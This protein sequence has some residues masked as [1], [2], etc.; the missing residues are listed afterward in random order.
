MV[1]PGLC[2]C[3]RVSRI[4]VLPYPAIYDLDIA[5]ADADVSLCD[6]DIGENA[7]VTNYYRK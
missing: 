5:R 7:G 2:D 3:R 6:V 1:V 4:R